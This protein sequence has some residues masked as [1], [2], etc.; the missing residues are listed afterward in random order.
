[1]AVR[2]AARSE[3][4]VKFISWTC[5]SSGDSFGDGDSITYIAHRIT[6]IDQVYIQ[7]GRFN[8]LL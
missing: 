1:M 2:A 4:N 6:K 8:P 3:G 5:A 7:G